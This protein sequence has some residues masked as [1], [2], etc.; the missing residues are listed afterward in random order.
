M[1]RLG[2][3]TTGF[4]IVE[5]LIVIVIIGI[6][7]AV[8]IVAFNGISQR[9]K[10]ASVL[11][12]ARQDASAMRVHY[13]IN[14]VYP[15]DCADAGVEVSPDNTLICNVAGDQ[16]SFCLA[17]SRDSF[18]FYVTQDLVQGAGTCSG[19]VAVSA[20]AV[21]AFSTGGSHVCAVTGGVAYCWGYNNEGQLGNGTTT[22]SNTPVPVDTS[23]VLAGK[24]VTDI[25]AGSNH[26]CAVADG[27]AFC[28]G[29]N[30]NG[31]LGR[32]AGGSSSVP[33][34][35]DATGVLAGRT[36]TSITAGYL[37]SYAIADGK[38]YAWGE[39][40]DGRVGDNTFTTKTS[41]AAVYEAGVLAGKTIEQIS[42]ESTHACALASDNAV[43][44][45]GDGAFGGKGDGVTTDSNVPVAVDATGVLSGK[46]ITDLTT[47]A[48]YGCVVA[49]GAPYCWGY[50]ANGKLGNNSTSSVYTP[51]ATVTSGALSGKTVTAIT[52]GGLHTCAIADGAPYCWGFPADG[53]LGDG[54][55]TQFTV[56]V[57]VDI[58][59]TLSGLT[60]TGISA[61]TYYSCAVV[62]SDIYCWG[63]GSN[64]QH[65]NGNGTNTAV[66]D[67]R[68]LLSL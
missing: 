11:S 48:Y 62:T 52:S 47:G 40:G 25:S 36:V 28:W 53:A 27:E 31:R 21:Q 37:N 59:G 12:D 38:A 58:S 9:A 2:K 39:N 35:V 5:L 17:V 56:P 32:G 23:G 29:Y 67:T 8:T 63:R 18:T 44:C 41:P 66:P 1:Q 64:G 57:A 10:E 4:T 60:V 13:E 33:V 26:T 50:G 55:S 20:D 15:N 45:W 46:T 68:A 43:Y 6:L 30:A 54:S 49:D 34:A 22:P 65:G 19:T 42:S 16:Q 3:H 7:A 61:G 14:G 24:T 51:V